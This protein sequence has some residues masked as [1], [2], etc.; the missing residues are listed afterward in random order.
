[1]TTSHNSG[2]LY[3]M[4][5]GSRKG[6]ALFILKNSK[7]LIM[8]LCIVF[9]GFHFSRAYAAS[10]QTQSNPCG[11]DRQSLTGAIW[12]GVRTEGQGQSPWRLEV[13]FGEIGCVTLPEYINYLHQYLVGSAGILAV[14][15]IMFA[16]YRWIFSQGNKQKISDA[17][18]MIVTSVIGLAL[19]L[20]S[21]LLLNT[22]NP[23]TTTL[24]DLD[25]A[26][27]QSVDY[28]AL[29]MQSLCTRDETFGVYIG[30]K[31]FR[32]PTCGMAVDLV[33]PEEKESA[34]RLGEKP[35]KQY[36]MSTLCRDSG[37]VC[38]V[39]YDS[40]KRMFVGGGCSDH[41]TADVD[42]QLIPTDVDNDLF[43]GLLHYEKG[44]NDGKTG[45][46]CKD[47]ISGKDGNA[48]NGSFYPYTCV[49][50]TDNGIPKYNFL[51]DDSWGAVGSKALNEPPGCRF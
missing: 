16:G 50:T 5:H 39:T 3:V 6:K 37:E 42:G 12:N 40:E 10:E 18:D 8:A 31:S 13:P 41:I 47:F 25:L 17:Q 36:C 20:T 30:S 32:P 2:I 21:Y 28:N 44:E 51:R 35:R 33:S 38:I 49:L 26:P 15:M 23:A 14:V 1:M 46:E 45:S 7:L 27:L 4:K 22:L 11:A 29:A 43:C 34:I 24:T 19:A 9:F 48:P